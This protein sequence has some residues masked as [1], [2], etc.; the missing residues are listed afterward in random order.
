[1]IDIITFETALSAIDV[2]I[3]EGFLVKA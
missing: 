3:K 1:M 2:Y